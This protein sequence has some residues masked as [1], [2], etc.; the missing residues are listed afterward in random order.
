MTVHFTG[1]SWLF[2]ARAAV[3]LALGGYLGCST[4]LAEHGRFDRTEVDPRQEAYLFTS[5][6]FEREGK[7]A[8]ADPAN[9]ARLKV[10]ILDATTGK[11][12]ACRVN[13]VGSDGN[14]Y[15]PT[16]NSLKQ[17]S[18]TGTWPETLAGNRP[19]KA[20]IRY[21]GHFF[22]TTGEFSV[23]VPSGP[24][25]VEVWKGLE[26]R[27]E[28]ISTHVV[29]GTTRDLKL[30][31]SHAVPM[32][33]QGWHSGDP[34]LHFIR[35]NDQDDET[36]F[37]LL[38][39][40][41][42]HLGLVLCYNED[43]S[44][45]RGLM[46]AQAT[47]Q[48]RGLGMKSLRRRGPYQIIS[49]QEYRN[50]VLGHLNLFLR[51]RL[52]LDGNR[53]DPNNGPLFADIAT[54][55][56][57]QGGYA[58]HAHGGYGLEIWA[59]L[60]E[61]ATNGVEL[62]QFG[63]YR[64][65]GLDGWY[66]VLNAG[67]R[68]PGLAACDYPA[69]RK[70]GDCRTYAYVER[71]PTFESWLKAVA[72]GR[73]FMTTAPLLFLEV[74][75]RK[76]GDI[77][78]TTAG[79]AQKLRARV[80]VRSETAPVTNVQLVV[81][82]NVMRELVVSREAGTAQ[83][84]ELEES[85]DIN[86]STWIAARAFS[87]SPD[88]AAD[89]ESHTNPVYVYADGQLP[90]SADSAD[91]LIARIDEQIQDQQRRESPEKQRAIEYFQRARKTL[92]LRKSQRTAAAGPAIQEKARATIRAAL[93]EPIL[94]ADLPLTE[95]RAFVMPRI[96]VL[97]KPRDLHAWKHQAESMRHDMLAKVVLRGVPQE[98]LNENPKVEW[99]D[100]IAGGPGYKIRKLRYEV[101]PG[102]WIPALLYLPEK[103]AGPV[104][105]ALSLNG[106]VREGK[107]ADYKQLLSIN[108]AKRGLLVLDPEWFGMGQ[109]A[110]PGFSH[111]RMN[112]LDLCGMAGLA[113]FYLALSRALDV[114]L[115][116]EHVDPA[117]VLVTGLSGGGW[118]TCLIAGLDQRVTLANP[119]AGYGSFRTNVMVDDL[120]DS[121]QSPTDM[122]TVADY[123]HLTAMRAPRPTLLTYNAT[124]DC[125]FRAGNTLSPLLDAARPIFELYG[126]A[127]RLRAHIN[128]DPGTHNFE[129]ENREQLY[130][131][132]GDFF[133]PGESKFARDEIDSREELKTAEGLSVPLPA[134]NVDFSGLAI[135]VLASKA[136]TAQ[137]APKAVVSPQTKNQQQAALVELLKIPQY[138]VSSQA[139]TAQQLPNLAIVSRQL[140][141][142]TEPSS[143]DAKRAA[144]TI[145]C[146]EIVA[147]AAKPPKL[148]ILI[149]DD[150]KA[151]AADSAQRLV[152][153]G[154]RV[155]ALDPLGWGES[156]IVA[157]DPHYLF[158]LFLAAVG[159][160]PLGI[161]AG[162]LNA[163]ATWAR[164]TF[165]H[166]TVC[167][168]AIGP[169]ATT[170]AIVA[171][172]SESR[173]IQELELTGALRSLTQ[174]ISADKTVE[175]FPELFA[176]G[177]LPDFDV[178]RLLELVAPRRVEL[179]EPATAPAS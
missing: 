128:H 89:A 177:L 155:L 170:A 63:I 101:L 41:D 131:A 139:E 95:F 120:G 29:A 57:E 16:E 161:Q 110:T 36:I 141:C 158:P 40:E 78:Q 143:T 88:G 85:V 162:Q 106:H 124:D 96:A 49:G 151:S 34:H 32:A 22:Y 84:L 99:F 109:L 153:D 14:F 166:E 61:G 136:G 114:G 3:V 175:Q 69:C 154:Y 19:G 179:R 147:T 87:R 42:I 92:L 8:V 47:P 113:P 24:V 33:A 116:L 9:S 43:T 142:K 59:D 121:E 144:W 56:R 172:A 15:Q 65:I 75:D 6:G 100:T 35:S 80:R 165:P 70:L 77:I 58:F 50:G 11:P 52:A 103:L 64:G 13:V 97:E 171:A 23:D 137:A 150:G 30:S 67:F 2:T 39:A 18:L 164:E 140:V 38:E 27:A 133:Y 74:D 105:L 62:L 152:S 81:G 1:A 44:D 130:A 72:D 53:L 90:F 148:A 37:N 5:A 168:A 129:R 173:G 112:Q 86:Q 31:L 167:I 82:G 4:A 117:R 66:H 102:M 176:F 123:A 115:S 107:A 71:E 21:F 48:L 132:I 46:P 10:T 83:W 26:F 119:V 125:C 55:T 45:Y 104:P 118:Q 163:V 146:V 126:A 20:P 60:V 94:P 12:T 51:D 127:D 108:L 111:Y 25:R 68:F 17:F 93:A 135:R 91:W 159:E 7:P 98:W 160:R 174:L 73:S 145:P 134:G 149:A 169:R 28:Q 122:A 138:S 54:E 76:P 79:Q 156:K 178:P 157:Q